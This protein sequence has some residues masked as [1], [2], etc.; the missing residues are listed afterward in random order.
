MLS[1]YSTVT[2]VGRPATWPL[3]EHWLERHHV[4]MSSIM[5][6]VLHYLGVWPARLRTRID[7]ATSCRKL[8]SMAAN[9]ANACT[10]SIKRLSTPKTFWIT[11]INAGMADLRCSNCFLYLFNG[12]VQCSCGDRLCGDCYNSFKS[13]WALR[14]PVLQTSMLQIHPRT[15]S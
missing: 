13:R 8:K 7:D 15:V 9:C 5:Q 1:I 10:A 12:P 4:F 3:T 11:P 14:D 2:C 6:Y